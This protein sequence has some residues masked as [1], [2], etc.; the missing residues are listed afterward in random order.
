[1]HGTDGNEGPSTK[2]SAS[3]KHFFFVPKEAGPPSREGK[4]VLDGAFGETRG[5]PD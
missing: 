4:M 1:M 2:T 3:F 5:N